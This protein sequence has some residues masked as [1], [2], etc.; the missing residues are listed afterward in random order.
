MA[1][2]VAAFELVGEVGY[3]GLTIEGIA[4][5]AGCGKQTIYRWWP[6]RPTFSS[7]HSQ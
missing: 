7:K 6:S 3:A 5:R 4:N 2:L 1:I